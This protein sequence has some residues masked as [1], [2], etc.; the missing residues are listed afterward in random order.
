[1]TDDIAD[2]RRRAR[3][4]LERYRPD[5]PRPAAGESMAQWDRAWRQ[6]MF[7]GGWAA[8][9]WPVEYGGRAMSSI[10]QLAWADEYVDAGMPVE[11]IF[12]VAVYHVGPTLLALGTP[13]QKERFLPAIA[14]G[15]AS[16][17]QCFS[18]P[19]A[20]SDLAAVRT[21]GRVEGD[22][23]VINGRK[24]WSTFAQH[25][26][27][28][29]TLIRTSQ[30]SRPHDGLTWLAVDMSSPGITVEPI[31]TIDGHNSFSAVE[32]DDVKVPM[33]NVVGTVSGGWRTAMITLAHERGPSW[34][35][36]RLA[37]LRDLETLARLAEEVGATADCSIAEALNSARTLAAGLR[38]LA[39]VES[40][41]SNPGPETSA[42][43]LLSAQVQVAVARLAMSILGPNRMF[44]G[45]WQDNWLHAFSKSIGGGTSDI[46]RNI[47]GERLLGLPR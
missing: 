37:P 25:A 33:D 39:Y 3:S 44:G 19:E 32:F 34:L 45:R 18:E 47:I 29:E 7:H 36:Q 1:L 21:Q 41:E 17:C 46:Q 11:S 31:P 16:W 2:F 5:A 42:T 26:D 27:M 30:G 22:V 40:L 38:S 23:I 10:F 9:G 8:L 4:W 14:A 12:D 28:A 43:I 15:T 24:V 35:E 6:T 13:R 20:G